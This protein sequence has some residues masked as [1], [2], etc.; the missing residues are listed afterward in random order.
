MVCQR[1]LLPIAATALI[2]SATACS[3]GGALDGSGSGS[4]TPTNLKRGNVS[5]GSEDTES[6]E[7]DSP[8]E[9]AGGFLTCAYVST[10]ESGFPE[11]E[12]LVPVGC[13]IAKNGQKVTNPNHT[14]KMGLYHQ[15]KKPD[16]MVTRQASPSSRWHGYG[17]LPRLNKSD[18]LLGI[19]VTNQEDNLS[20]GPI[21][22]PVKDLKPISQ[23]AML[24]LVGGYRPSG[25]FP[26]ETA[27]PNQQMMVD[28]GLIQPLDNKTSPIVP[29][30]VC[31]NGVRRKEYD[32]SQTPGLLAMG[33]VIAKQ[34][35]TVVDSPILKMNMDLKPTHKPKEAKCFVF[36]KEAAKEK[37]DKPIGTPK[38]VL[39]GEGCLILQSSE[40]FFIYDRDAVKKNNLNKE[41]LESYV[42]ARLC[43]D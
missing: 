37:W 40:G 2:W 25:N 14:Y 43:S 27:W 18:H 9:I 42:N 23:E 38:P 28:L 39:E 15:D 1:K 26:M 11:S 19:T 30:T 41:V 17:H 6:N 29:L 12:D 10:S 8:Q 36:A 4:K 13:G 31:E 34:L 16:S 35:G 24:N 3:S 21:Y 33:G 22:F 20:E 5:S 32:M 7:A